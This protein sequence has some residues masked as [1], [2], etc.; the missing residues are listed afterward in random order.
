M[1]QKSDNGS[2]HGPQIVEALPEGQS[3]V[4]SVVRVVNP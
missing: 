3:H 2:V 4:R 1:T